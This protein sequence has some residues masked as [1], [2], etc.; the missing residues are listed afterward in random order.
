MNTT[1]TMPLRDTLVIGCGGFGLLTIAHLKAK[2]G[3]FVDLKSL[4]TIRFLGVDTA[5]SLESARE[6]IMEFLMDSEVVKISA[7]QNLDDIINNP[8][9]YPEVVKTL[10]DLDGLSEEGRQKLREIIDPG[11]GAGVQRLYSRLCL[12]SLPNNLEELKNSIDKLFTAKGHSP[13]D[14]SSVSVQ[15][16]P[17]E[18]AHIFIAS[19]LYGG[20]GSGIF[21]DIAAL[22]RKIAKEK[23]KPTFVT[24]IFYLPSF[25]DSRLDQH[26]KAQAYAA[27]K[28]LDHFMSGNPLNFTYPG[29]IQIEIT[30]QTG[31][32][33]IFN[34]AFLFD[35]PTKAERLGGVIQERRSNLA[36]SGAELIFHLCASGFGTSFFESHVNWAAANLAFVKR[37]PPQQDSD[38][39]ERKVIDQRVTAYSTARIIT[40]GLDQL[41][42]RSY[43]LDR[44]LMNL[45]DDYCGFGRT[46]QRAEAGSAKV[47][48]SIMSGFA[49]EP[50]LTRKLGITEE[51]ILDVYRSVGIQQLFVDETVPAQIA[52]LED[53][54]NS[55]AQEISRKTEI[56][57]NK[58][59][60]R[61]VEEITKIEDSH[62]PAIADL[63]LGRLR[64][65]MGDQKLRAELL[66]HLSDLS[67]Q[68]DTASLRERFA[69]LRTRVAENIR[70]ARQRVRVGLVQGAAE[71]AMRV[72][73]SSRASGAERLGR[74][75]QDTAGPAL[76]EVRTLTDNALNLYRYKS[77]I[78]LIDKVL[79]LLKDHQERSVRPRKERLEEVQAK[80]RQALDETDPLLLSQR[81]L[82]YVPIAELMQ[83]RF[84]E[85]C[86]KGFIDPLGM[87]KRPAKIA[88]D[89]RKNGLVM[90]NGE[91]AFITGISNF[92]SSEI[93]NALNKAIRERI[94]N[95]INNYVIDFND[96]SIFPFNN[97]PGESAFEEIMA[98]LREVDYPLLPYSF[99]GSQEIMGGIIANSLISTGMP[100][101]K[102]ITSADPYEGGVPGLVTYVSLR[103]GF[104][105]SALRDLSDWKKEYVKEISRKWPVHAIKS[106]VY[107][108]EP[109]L[110]VGCRLTLGGDSLLF[111]IAASPELSVIRN[112]Q[113]TDSLFFGDKADIQRLRPELR[114]L[115]LDENDN[116]KGLQ[117]VEFI[118]HITRNE[119][120][121][122]ELFSRVV[123]EIYRRMLDRNSD[124]R[125]PLLR[126]KLKGSWRRNGIEKQVIERFLNSLDQRVGYRATEE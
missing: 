63:L 95:F 47:V 16:S 85:R 64:T 21:L 56:E 123:S 90:E 80:I 125:W 52:G 24:G 39:H 75:I 19:S 92:S 23:N 9:S 66:R 116:P 89:I 48:E 60:A 37:Y 17:T 31:A 27:L 120:L 6:M 36:E 102:D 84:V 61:I 108:T 97:P 68:V 46:A 72:V 100:M 49:G 40:V 73:F 115:F 79:V 106:A 57:A 118:N 32:D 53:R 50:P 83:K 55:A 69:G 70:I 35:C 124:F 114:G 86:Y 94:G 119:I 126:D 87:D 13:L 62:G 8:G 121:A 3:Q 2:L 93:L 25:M 117:Q 11:E 107:M 30:N 59:G 77:A 33:R 14:N 76:N 71:R 58:I 10:P 22:C 122:N 45:M 98:S 43:I 81:R 1:T 74:L 101:W 88:E 109:Y 82:G 65:E 26:C 44:F 5:R 103:M 105:L 12:R 42:I 111:D 78:D 51:K 104:P 113:S 110:E 99:S 20:T 67:G 41:Q 4:K 7:A 28:E 96:K 91:K 15:P 29:G 18:W 54:I 38:L 34:M 112:D